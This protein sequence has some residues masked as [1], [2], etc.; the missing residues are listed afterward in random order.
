VS[1]GGRAATR[2]IFL[3]GLGEIGRNMIAIESGG[4]ILVIDAGLSF[5][6]DEML[7]VDLVLPDFSYVAERA[8]RCVGVVL[9]HGHEDHVGALSWFLREVDVPVYGT[10]LTLGMARKRLDE[11]GQEARM[12]EIAAP[13]AREIGPFRCR[14]LPVSHS[15]PDA[16]SIAIDTVDGRVLYTGDFKLDD[17]PIDGRHTDIEGFRSLGDEGVDLMLS[18]STNAET[19][20]RT[21]SE[22]LVG[23]ALRDIFANAGGR[24]IVACFASNLHRIQQVCEAAEATGRHVAFVG[25]SMVNNVEVGRELGHVRVAPSTVVGIEDLEQLPPDR[26]VVVCT[27]S[28]GEPFS[29]LSLIASGEHKFVS[30]GPEDTVILSASPIPGNESAVHRVINGLYKAGADVYHSGTS[31]VHVSGHA[32]SEELA[33]L[34]QTVRPRYFTPV[35]GEF[36]Q[37]ALHKKLAERLG[38]GEDMINI[39]EDGNVLELQDGKVRRGDN[40]RAGMILVDGLGVG[41]VGPVV[42]RDR[43]V[44]AGDGILVC[45]VTIDSHS[46]ELIA[47]P[48]LIS[49]GFI[50]EERSRDL[51][52]EA[53]DLVA[54][55]LEDLEG[56][57]MTDWAVVKKTCRRALGEFVWQSTRRRPMLLPIVIEV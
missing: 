39:V 9:T 2:V 6:N 51:L 25:R 19:P 44:L 20:G 12:I 22:S 18:D 1:S 55:A 21:P 45:V 53:A 8:E 3:G 57:Q 50:F 30:V 26:S 11:A 38:I 37:L 16:I 43:R 31:Q 7:G 14:F 36:R 28:Q 49:R 10:P 41:D 24:I 27:G 23:N 32:A 4:D 56:E 52:D 47:G 29:A 40:V 15:I 35:H 46:G 34:L 13:G 5:P 48:D 42:L 17:A 33:E 54:D